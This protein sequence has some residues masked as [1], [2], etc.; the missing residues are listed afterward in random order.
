MRIPILPL[1]AL[2]LLAL[3]ALADDYPQWLG[4]KR[5]NIYR[6]TD[7]AESFPAGGPKILWRTPVGG[8]YAGMAVAGDRVILTDRQLK[9]GVT[10][11]KDP[12]ARGSIAG[13]ERVLCLDDATGKEVWRVE[14]DCPYTISYA[15]GPRATPAVDA[16]S[17]RV[18]TLGAQGHVYCIDIKSGKTIWNKRLDGDAPMWGF[19]GHPVLEGDNV[20]VLGSGAPLI[21]AFNKATGDVAW[22]A[23]QAKLPGYAPPTPHT[24]NGRR[25]IVQ[26]YTDGVLA[27]DAKT[28]QELWRQAHG[29][30]QN[31]VAIVTPLFIADDT[32]VLSS[33]YTGAAAIKVESDKPQLLWEAKSKGRAP[34]TL[35]SLHSQM[36]FHE[37][38]V[39]GVAQSGD[40]LCLD[41]KAG[42]VV[43]TDTKPLLGDGERQQWTAAFLTPWQPDANQPARHFYLAT[44]TGDLILCD[45]DAKGYKELARAHLLEPVNKDANRPTLWS[46]PAY[47]HGS[48]YWRN[49]KEIVRASLAK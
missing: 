11:P 44:E 43:W 5:D 21:V 12:F 6:E 17:G 31:G 45:L 23:G 30:E 15:A 28:G 26:Y 4:P 2:A 13:T 34:T 42:K 41:P 8:G 47:A 9:P 33:A 10:A 32:F 37:G 49:D 35:H 14:Y 40:L 24:F 18:Y 16:G 46:H 20:V 19:A 7:V 27:V 25:E 22:T 38:H 29:P 48:I 3:P 1:F 36:V 39:F